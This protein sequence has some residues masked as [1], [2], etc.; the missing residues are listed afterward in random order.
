VQSAW[1]E[2]AAPGETAEQLAAELRLMATWLNLTDVV[3]E[4]RGDLA[5][6]LTAAV[7]R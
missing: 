6:A 2:P 5:P 4:A 1:S 3:V 7:G